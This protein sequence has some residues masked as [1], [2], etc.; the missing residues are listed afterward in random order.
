MGKVTFHPEVLDPPQTAALQ[1]SGRLLAA[2]GFRLAGGTAL[3]LL[4]GHR[5]SVDF[6]WF[7][8]SEMGDSMRLA[9]DLRDQGLDLQ[10]EQ[11]SRSEVTGTPS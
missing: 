9:G 1:R 8:E 7:T 3:A 5:K 2:R 10:V 4:L 6:D 11:V